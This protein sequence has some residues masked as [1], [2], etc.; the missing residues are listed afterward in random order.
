MT[1]VSLKGTHRKSF[2][3][4]KFCLYSLEGAFMSDISSFRALLQQLKEK[5]RELTT[6]EIENSILQ[7]Q[8]KDLQALERERLRKFQ[9]ESESFGVL[10]RSKVSQDGKQRYQFFLAYFSGEIAILRETL[11]RYEESKKAEFQV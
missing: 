5:F 9:I 2:A 11:A 8:I 6:K 4:I 3:L 10:L 1:A 7:K